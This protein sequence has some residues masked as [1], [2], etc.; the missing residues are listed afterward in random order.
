MTDLAPKWLR[1][2]SEVVFGAFLVGAL[3]VIGLLI[4]GLSMVVL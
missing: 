1:V 2:L 3:A 4:Y